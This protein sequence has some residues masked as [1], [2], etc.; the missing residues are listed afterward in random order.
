MA[1]LNPRG[2]PGNATKY[3]TYK[4]PGSAEIALENNNLQDAT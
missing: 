3:Q 2:I 4:S 1:G